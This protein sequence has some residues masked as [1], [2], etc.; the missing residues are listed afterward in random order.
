MDEMY[1]LGHEYDCIIKEPHGYFSYD[2]RLKEE[3]LNNNYKRFHELNKEVFFIDDGHELI[4][5]LFTCSRNIKFNDFSNNISRPSN[6]KEYYESFRKLKKF[7]E[8]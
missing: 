2:A 5:K 7:V 6:V 3:T 8:K 1:E 4:K